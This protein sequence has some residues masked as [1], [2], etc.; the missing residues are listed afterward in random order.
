MRDLSSFERER[1]KSS[2]ASLGNS[3]QSSKEKVSCF[4]SGEK[5]FHIPSSMEVRIPLRVRHVFA[6]SSFCFCVSIRSSAAVRSANS[7]LRTSIKSLQASALSGSGWK[8][9]PSNFVF[10]A[11]SYH[12]SS[13]ARLMRLLRSMRPMPMS[14]PTS[15]TIRPFSFMRALA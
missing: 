13:S 12:R 4:C 7:L 6:G 15:L 11:L 14:K 1:K 8:R 10:S 3:C 9:C 5:S 2:F